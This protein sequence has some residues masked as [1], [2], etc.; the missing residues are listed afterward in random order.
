LSSCFAACRRFAVGDQTELM[1]LSLDSSVAS[2][3]ASNS[4]RL[5]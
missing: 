5:Q 2:V 3:G 4:G 1:E